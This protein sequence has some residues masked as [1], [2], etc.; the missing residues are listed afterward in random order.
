[1]EENNEWRGGKKGGQLVEE[2]DGWRVL[3]VHRPQDGAGS[4]E[5]RRFKDKDFGDHQKSKEAACAWKGSM[6]DKKGLTKNMFRF[7][8]DHVEVRLN[9]SM[10]MRIDP[11]DLGLAE[12]YV[13]SAFS[14]GVRWYAKSNHGYFHKLATGFDHTDHI[15]RDGLDNRR[16][17]LRRATPQLNANNRKKFKTNS[18]GVSGVLR[19][20]PKK[21]APV[22]EARWMEENKR[23]HRT[24]STSVHGEEGAKR[25]AIEAREEACKRLRIE[26]E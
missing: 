2:S 4:H 23:V 11:V 10:C 7:L 12:R 5:S 17:N 9:N 26:N 24:F 6:S 18:S 20:E 19:L 8:E 16:S 15:N 22:W 25:K 1:M 3:F 13:W 21:R 14:H